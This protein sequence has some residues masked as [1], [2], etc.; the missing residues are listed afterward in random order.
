MAVGFLAYAAFMAFPLA[1]KNTITWVI[2]IIGAVA[3][4]FLFEQPWVFPALIILGGITTNVSRKRIP[5]T[6]QKPRK[7][8]MV[9]LLAFRN[10]FYCRGYIQ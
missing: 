4:Y 5:Q 3:T 2:M 6:E 7:I 9:E 1:I 10:H 8:K